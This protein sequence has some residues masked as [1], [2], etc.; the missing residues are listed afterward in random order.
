MSSAEESDFLRM[1][2]ERFTDAAQADQAERDAFKEDVEFLAGKQWPDNIRTMREKS[3]PPRPCL[4]INKVQEKVD[5]VSGDFKQSEPSVHIIPVDSK[6]DPKTAEIFG[7]LIRNIEYN[8]NAKLGAYATAFDNVIAGGRGA[9]RVRVLKD[10]SGKQ[11]IRIVRMPNPLVVYWDQ[12]STAIDL[13]DARFMFVTEMKPLREFKSQ[14]PDANVEDW[15]TSDPK[16]EQLWRSEGKVR[17]AEYW[18]WA[19]S[20]T[21]PE[22]ARGVRKKL[23]SCLMCANQILDGPHEWPGRY[24][25]IVVPLGKELWVGDRRTNRGMVRTAKEPQ[26]MYNF[27]SSA[28]TEQIALAPTA[29]FLVTGTHLE[30]SQE[31]W[32]DQVKKNRHYLVYT[33]DPLA[34]GGPS[35]E[36]PPMM[37][38]AI[39]NELQR[40]E[41]DIMSSM[42]LYQANLGDEGQEK[43]GKAIL[44]RQREGD[45]GAY[46]FT[47]NFAAALTYNGKV[48]ID[49]IQR[50]MDM[51]DIIRIRGED[52][53][54]EEITINQPVG[55]GEEMI[56]P[57]RIKQMIAS[58]QFTAPVVYRPEVSPYLNDLTVGT[59]DIQVDIGPSYNTQRQEAA[60]ALLEI[61]KTVPQAGVAAIDLI[62][63]NLDVPGAQELQKRLEKM[64]PPG[65][66][67]LRPDE[68]PPPEPPPDPDLVKVQLQHDKDMREAT[69]KEF[70]T[71]TNAIAKL[72]E[73][74][75]KERGNQL[76]EMRAI[77]E[78]IRAGVQQGN[79][80]R[81]KEQEL[82]AQAAQPGNSGP[83]GT[84]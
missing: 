35:R 45:T 39:V 11:I 77:A 58:P 47:H 10:E 79:E 75:A 67:E 41:H 32:D 71:F 18:Y 19:S 42:G 66:R 8:S 13:S 37:S 12:T 3:D 82:A 80:Q 23:Y 27:W 31:M 16:E 83:G 30:D 7:G 21:K 44:A 28:V 63:K 34:P 5:Q 52:G 20:P 29:P 64:V 36:Q 59:Y 9:W 60:A 54:E 48:L 56:H 38:T 26:Q 1:A 55:L 25:P 62:V 24:I 33:P 61:V 76:E 22:E 65:I 78:N 17:V 53:S 84:Q 74:E 4:V 6:G 2:R 15:D 73:A 81:N 50:T 43:S 69:R 46:G 72:M 49:L 57:E 68:P 70:E 40:M 14:Y 51:E